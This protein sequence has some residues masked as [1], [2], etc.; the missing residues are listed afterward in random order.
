M[1][2]T[3]IEVYYCLSMIESDRSATVQL[4]HSI[5]NNW[6]VILKDKVN[7]KSKFQNIIIKLIEEESD[8]LRRRRRMLYHCLSLIDKDRVLS[9]SISIY[10]WYT[11]IEFYLYLSLIDRDRVISLT[12][13]NKIEFKYKSIIHS[14]TFITIHSYICERS[15]R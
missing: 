1:V 9:L 2:E 15:R 10:H 5:K 11:K 13:T 8:K 7:K 14:R 6:K 3:L 12:N 4:I